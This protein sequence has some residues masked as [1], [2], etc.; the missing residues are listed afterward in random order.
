MELVCLQCTHQPL[1][2]SH[3]NGLCWHVLQA[4]HLLGADAGTV[5]SL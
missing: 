4:Q 3:N 1:Q 5:C 2:C